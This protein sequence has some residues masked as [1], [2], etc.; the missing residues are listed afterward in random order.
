MR[1]PSELTFPIGGDMEAQAM[2]TISGPHF[3]GIGGHGNGHP[4]SESFHALHF[5]HEKGIH[6]SNRRSR[7]DP[8]AERGTAPSISEMRATTVAGSSD[9]NHAQCN[10]R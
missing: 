10:A 7:Q 3:D 6:V 8:R 4:G 5:R 2:A 1:V 9:L